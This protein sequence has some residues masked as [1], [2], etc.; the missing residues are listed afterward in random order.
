MLGKDVE[1]H[2]RGPRVCRPS[3]RAARCSPE[4]SRNEQQSC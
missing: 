2:M 3:G 1:R 4:G